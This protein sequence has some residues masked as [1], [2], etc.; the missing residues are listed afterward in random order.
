MDDCSKKFAEQLKSKLPAAVRITGP[1]P[2]P[3]AKAKNLYRAQ[4]MLWA[5]AARQ[6]VPVLRALLKVFKPPKGITIS[7]NVDALSLM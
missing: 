6:Y 1:A 3:L 2:A 5:A 7:V 4:F